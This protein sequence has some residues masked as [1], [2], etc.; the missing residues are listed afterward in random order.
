M[1]ISSHDE[2][3]YLNMITVN[4]FDT[5]E[6][7]EEYVLEQLKLNEPLDHLFTE[8]PISWGQRVLERVDKLESHVR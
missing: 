2:D 7:F 3:I 1:S 6:E 8:V 5:V 4:I